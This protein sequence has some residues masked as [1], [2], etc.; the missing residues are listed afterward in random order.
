M[1]NGSLRD[2]LVFKCTDGS[3]RDLIPETHMMAPN[4]L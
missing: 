1:T 3:S 4:Y 2:G